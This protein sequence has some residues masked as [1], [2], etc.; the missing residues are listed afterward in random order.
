MS[1]KRVA[2]FVLIAGGLLVADWILGMLVV[3]RVLHKWVYLLAN[4]PFG[5]VYVWTESL[6]VGSSYQWLG[7]AVSESLISVAQLAA[8]GAQALVYYGLWELWSR[9]RDS[10]SRLGRDNCGWSDSVKCLV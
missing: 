3:R 4:I 7:H 8:V 2:T 5:L 6:W 1:K 9:K 10:A